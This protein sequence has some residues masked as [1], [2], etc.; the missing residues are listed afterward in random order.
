M[1]EHVNELEAMLDEELIH[2]LDGSIADRIEDNH[3]E[4]TRYV[5]R[6]FPS[7]LPRESHC[8]RAL[9]LSTGRGNQPGDTREVIYAHPY[10]IMAPHL[11]HHSK[12]RKIKN[13]FTHLRQRWY[14]AVRAIE[15]HW[16]LLTT[17]SVAG[18][19]RGWNGSHTRHSYGLFKKMTQYPI[20]LC[21]DDKTISTLTSKRR[22]TVIE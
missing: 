8:L 12:T 18:W 13:K 6:P 22:K 20:T 19:L 15:S 2:A 7:S 5:S 11:I 17:L 21:V 10:D 9:I 4:K 3:K 14:F 1:E 16:P